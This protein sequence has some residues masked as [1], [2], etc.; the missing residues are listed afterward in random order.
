M[1]KWV[2]RPSFFTFCKH[3]HINTHTHTHTHTMFFSNKSW[4]WWHSLFELP[5]DTHGSVNDSARLKWQLSLGEP[6]AKALFNSPENYWEKHLTCTQHTKGWQQRWTWGVYFG[7][8]ERV[9]EKLPCR[10]KASRGQKNCCEEMAMIL[11]FSQR[12]NGYRWRNAILLSY[13]Y[14]NNF[15][16]TTKTSLILHSHSG[17]SALLHFLHT[18]QPTHSSTALYHRRL[19]VDVFLQTGC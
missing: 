15:A 5:K 14:K 17:M 4:W 19:K 13:I 3:W 6:S 1:I 18:F 9:N 8:K 7:P 10:K 2:L 11:I 12:H 16:L